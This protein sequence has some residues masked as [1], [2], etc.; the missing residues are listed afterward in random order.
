[1][2]TSRSILVTSALP[3]ANGPLHLGHIVE[4]IQTDIW[5]RFQKLNGHSCIYVCADDAHGTPIMI[6]AQQENTTPEALIAR[7]G[8]LH[9]QDIA[10]FHIGVDNFYTTHSPENQ[11]LAHEIYLSL[12]QAGSI[13][14]KTIK[15][16]YDPIKEMFLP[17]R[18]IRGQCP[19]C[20][21]LD[22]YGDH[23]EHCHH[24]YDAQE[25]VNPISVL[26]GVTPVEK[27]SVHYFFRLNDYA[28]MLKS[29]V[30]SGAVAT[31]VVNKLEEM[32]Q[33]NLQDWDI[34]RDAPYFGF[35]LPDHPDK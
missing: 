31:E 28:P 17:D 30:R 15:Q 32:L 33:D 20:G 21:A 7:I 29:W 4:F 11:K 26:S 5:V 14:T 9:R 34:S 25:L 22:Q 10:A 1:M 12:K 8:T 2:G 24:T 19:H 27:E 23:C 3:Y 18:F 6:K 35:T 16:A 13:V